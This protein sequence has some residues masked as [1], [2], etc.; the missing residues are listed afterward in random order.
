MDGLENECYWVAW[1]EIHRESTKDLHFEKKKKLNN[2]K[3]NN[4]K[5]R[6]QGYFSKTSFQK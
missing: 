4:K 3:G 6:K 2:K 1:W 5:K